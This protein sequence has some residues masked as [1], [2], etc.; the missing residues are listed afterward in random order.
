MK[1]LTLSLLLLLPL[2]ASSVANAASFDCTKAS[3][4]RERLI[5]HTPELSADDARLGAVYIQMLG[6][7]PPEAAALEKQLE[8]EWLR[9][10][11]EDCPA[12]RSEIQG[13]DRQ[14]E[15]RLREGCACLDGS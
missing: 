8:R 14:A 1:I 11:D 5:C 3:T 12:D 6:A 9:S 4:K 2:F 7:L 10:L 15:Q 13:K